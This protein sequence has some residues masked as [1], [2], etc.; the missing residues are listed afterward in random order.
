MFYEALSLSARWHKY[1]AN[2]TRRHVTAKAASHFDVD[3]PLA[4][5]PGLGQVTVGRWFCSQFS[6]AL[7]RSADRGTVE[8]CCF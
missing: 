5:K 3:S 1:E 8:L 4:T 6:S 7:L 2:G